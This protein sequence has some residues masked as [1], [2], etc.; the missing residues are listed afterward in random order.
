MCWTVPR[1]IREDSIPSWKT[2]EKADFFT[3]FSYIT[4]NS[5][6]ISVKSGYVNTIVIHIILSIY[7]SHILSAFSL[8]IEF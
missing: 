5:Q 1:A 7:E 8:V 4:V 6:D 3:N 2:I